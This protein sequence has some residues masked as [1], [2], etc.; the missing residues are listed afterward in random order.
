MCCV[1][2]PGTAPGVKD[3]ERSIVSLQ[4]EMLRTSA[5]ILESMHFANCS[6][7]RMR[8]LGWALHRVTGVSVRRGTSAH[9]Y[10]EKEDEDQNGD[11]R[12]GSTSQG[13]WGFQN[14]TQQ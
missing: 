14:L 8:P 13:P 2:I 1:S 5:T 9:R 6:P 3:I 4:E 7:V 10:S 12:D 11:Q